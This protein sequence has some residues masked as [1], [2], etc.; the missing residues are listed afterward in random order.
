M[1]EAIVGMDGLSRGIGVGD[2]ENDLAFLDVCGLLVAIPSTL[3]AAFL[4]VK[5]YRSKEGGS[6][7]GRR[8]KSIRALRSVIEC[9]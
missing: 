6:C 9:T 2:A 5:V 7:S 1:F 3:Q 8:G 4:Y